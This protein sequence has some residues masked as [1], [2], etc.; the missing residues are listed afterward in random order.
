MTDPDPELREQAYNAFLAIQRVI[1]TDRGV[2]KYD[3]GDPERIA[4]LFE[5]GDVVMLYGAYLDVCLNN[6]YNSLTRKGVKVDFHP[7]GC[8]HIGDLL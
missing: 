2:I 4:D 8:L 6:A 1:Q 7:E 5:P 3:T